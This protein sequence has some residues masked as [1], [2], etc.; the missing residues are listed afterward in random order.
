MNMEKKRLLRDLVEGFGNAQ[1]AVLEL[2]KEVK[3]TIDEDADTQ[4]L[5]FSKSYD[6]K[7][8]AL[9]WIA[10]FF[11]DYKKHCTTKRLLCR[12]S[13]KVAESLNEC[14]SAIKERELS[15][16]DF[17]DFFPISDRIFEISVSE[18]ESFCDSIRCCMEAL[19]W[20]FI[21]S[22]PKSAVMI[23]DSMLLFSKSAEDDCNPFKDDSSDDCDDCSED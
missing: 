9:V 10:T 17:D 16:G 1:H 19:F 6:G 15:L 14:I 23:M 2:L 21:G 11:S 7:T 20:E 12:K 18:L 4:D 8:P 22:S 3:Q 5:K 13:E